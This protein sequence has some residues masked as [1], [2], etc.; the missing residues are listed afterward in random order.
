MCSKNDLDFARRFTAVTKTQAVNALA[1]DSALKGSGQRVA[2]IVACVPGGVLSAT[3]L[4]AI[5][6]MDNGTFIPFATLSTAQPS[7]IIKVEDVGPLLFSEIFISAATS[8][9]TLGITDVKVT[10]PNM[11]V[12]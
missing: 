7:I 1:T 11:D 2:L 12:L 10:D 5:G 4:C 3:A 6:V 8:T 9:F